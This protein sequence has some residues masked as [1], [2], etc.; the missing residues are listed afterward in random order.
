MKRRQKQGDPRRAVGYVRVSTKEQKWGPSAQG[1][2]L[3]AWAAREGVELAVVFI[4]IGAAGDTAIADRPGLVACLAALE[5]MSAGTLVAANRGR[6]AREI[7]IIR[8]VERQSLKLGAVLKTADGMSDTDDEAGHIRKG[9]DD[10]L[11]EAELRRI[12]ARTRAAL[13]VKKARGERT[14]GVP[15]GWQVG[16][17][18]ARLDPVPAEQAVLGLARDLSTAGLSTRAIVAEITTRGIR[19]RNGR[20]FNQ[21]QV[22]RILVSA[23]R[24]A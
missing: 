13:A 4:D 11:N 3:S 14:G 6:V 21:T 22:Q 2:A 12:R 16:A 23:R 15:Y 19:S 18:G 24:A 17:D 5:S 8:S 1:E 20:P 9:F 7:E 10:L